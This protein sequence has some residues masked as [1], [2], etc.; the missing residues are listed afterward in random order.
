MYSE[1][2]ILDEKHLSKNIR[3][4][5]REKIEEKSSI[6]ANK[7]SVQSFK[8]TSLPA[9]KSHFLMLLIMDNVREIMII[10]N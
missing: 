10:S 5:Q 7:R 1:L 4:S 3:K 2:S 9:Q 6:Y 8:F